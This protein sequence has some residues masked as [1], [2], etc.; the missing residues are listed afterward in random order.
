MSKSQKVNASSEPLCGT[1]VPPSNSFRSPCFSPQL[2]LIC[3]KDIPVLVVLNSPNA[4]PHHVCASC[5]THLS[6]LNTKLCPFWRQP[7]YLAPP[8]PYRM[9]SIIQFRPVRHPG[10]SS[11][12]HNVFRVPPFMCSTF[13]LISL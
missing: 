4:V 12:I 9:C 10:P 5:S 6:R 2:C 13:R 7:N 3:Y 8:D 1:S 11:S